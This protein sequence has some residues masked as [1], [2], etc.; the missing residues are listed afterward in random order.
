MSKVISFRAQVIPS[1][2][3]EFGEGSYK[4][5]FPLPSV[6]LAEQKLG[7]SLRSPSEWFAAKA[8]DIPVLL[9]AGLRRHHPDITEDRLREMCEP[10]DPEAIGEVAAA[11]GALAFPR[12]T[13]QYEKNLATLREKGQPAPK[14]AGRGAGR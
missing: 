12:W 11:L 3:L 13:E 7:R 1:L 6:A 2:T 4:V 9:Y 10:L 8:E 14:K 5:E